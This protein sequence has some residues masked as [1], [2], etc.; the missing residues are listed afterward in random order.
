MLTGKVDSDLFGV[1][2]ISLRSL[3]NMLIKIL[4]ERE[5]VAG[6]SR[7]VACSV[8]R[9]E[10]IKMFNADLWLALGAKIERV[11]GLS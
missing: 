3:C 9:I 4:I 6:T 8:S 1:R 5:L 2:N 10:M 7:V 11:F